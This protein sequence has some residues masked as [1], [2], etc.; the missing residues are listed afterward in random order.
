MSWNNLGES[1]SI[2]RSLHK[3]VNRREEL[4][5]NEREDKCLM[6]IILERNNCNVATIFIN[7]N[8]QKSSYIGP[9]AAQFD[10]LKFSV[11]LGSDENQKGHNWK[12]LVSPFTAVVWPLVFLSMFYFTRFF[13][14]FSV[15]SIFLE[16]GFSSI[17]PLS[18]G[19]TWNLILVWLYCSFLIRNFYTSQMYSHLT[20]FPDPTN[21]PK[22]IKELFDKKTLPI[23]CEH[24]LAFH[25]LDHI[26]F[27]NAL[28]NIS[29]FEFD[30][31]FSAFKRIQVVKTES[32]I[33]QF[34][35]DVSRSRDISCEAF[36]N[37][38][39]LFAKDRT[40]VK[41][42]TSSRFALL[43]YSVGTRRA[44]SSSYLTPVL[45]LFGNRLI[46]KSINDL[47]FMSKP[48]L[49]VC[50]KKLFFYDQVQFRI[51][52]LVDSGIINWLALNYDVQ[53]QAEI[54]KNVSIEAG[55]LKGI[56]FFMYALQ[57]NT[58]KGKFGGKTGVVK[59]ENWNGTSIII[60]NQIY[61][62]LQT[63]GG[64][65]NPY[66]AVDLVPYGKC[67]TTFTDGIPKFQC[68][69][70]D[71]DDE[72]YKIHNCIISQNSAAKSLAYCTVSNRENP[73][74]FKECADSTGLDFTRIESCKNSW[75][76][77]ILFA[78]M[79]VKHRSL[80]V[81]PSRHPWVVFNDEYIADDYHRA[82][83]DFMGLVCEKLK[84]M[85][86]TGPPQCLL[87]TN[88]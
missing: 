24:I 20:K 10:S 75:E 85:N 34:W 59:N 7:A 3:I 32:Q 62:A 77:T 31:Y 52:S 37:L 70:G 82:T 8:T 14:W 6:N 16:K 65:F 47:S 78:A 22:S 49:W 4:P 84:L 53:Q 18:K 45:E 72:A 43:S 41:C 26:N 30:P 68:R 13:D 79:G 11:I 29:S 88:N 44:Y 87:E 2:I 28:R 83:D 55:Y 33:P 48:V 39:L 27:N 50:R 9:F 67:N 40:D 56:N 71:R 86:I 21:L 35:K 74:A 64:V 5:C 15:I 54:L 19:A 63:L 25:L 66:L 38:R 42:K 57:R 81:R 69:R 73:Y 61:T 60:P 58:A 1:T 23:L 12:D 51:G 46:Y 17:I 36:P 80:V 76:G